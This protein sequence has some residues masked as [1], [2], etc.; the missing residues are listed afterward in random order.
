M[1]TF[2][3]PLDSNRLVFTR[4]QS[5]SRSSLWPLVAWVGSGRIEAPQVKLRTGDKHPSLQVF[6]VIFFLRVFDLNV[7]QS[8]S[9]N[10]RKFVHRCRNERYPCYMYRKSK[11][12][13]NQ[14]DSRS[15]RILPGTF[16][17]SVVQLCWLNGLICNRRLL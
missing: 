17:S 10:T 7:F 13:L 9:N 15:S 11:M 5:L 16:C 4:K 6:D 2:T 8:D 1:L 12:C 3:N 14:S